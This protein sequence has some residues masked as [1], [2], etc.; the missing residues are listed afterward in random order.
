MRNWDDLQTILALGRAGTMKG[1][2]AVLSVSETTISRRIQKITEGD[3]AALF[4]RNGHKWT[5]TSLGAQLIE[6][7]ERVEAEIIAAET[8]VEAQS[9][10]LTG[11]LKISSL[12]FINTHFIT[13]HV[14]RFQ[15]KHPG[16]TIMLDASDDVV[17]LAYRQADI[18]LR[19]SRPSEGRLI[20][21]R[22][23]SIPMIAFS[24]RGESPRDW[25]GL[26]ENLDWTPEMK[27]G[28]AHFGRAPLVRLDS[29][30]GI[31]NAAEATG[32]GGVAPTCM[33]HQRR[34]LQ[35]AS[36]PSKRE[37]WLTYH[38]D[39]RGSLRARAGVDWLDEVLG[40]RNCLC[41]EC[42]D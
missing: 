3:G 21:K 7:A 10:R 20:A 2:A 25:V 31:L 6:V 14:A 13:P 34:R 12:S 39:L 37:I 9:D 24:R 30:D 29:F 22:L 4:D 15:L 35:A 38:E 17:S 41:G 27:T 8:Q 5:P 26:T 36:A 28:F 11:V 32:M 1:A 42:T 19:L 33:V 40:D 23:C 16:L 18:A